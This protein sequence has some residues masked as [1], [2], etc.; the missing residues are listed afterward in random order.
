MQRGLLDN[1]IYKKGRFTACLMEM[2]KT[3]GPTSLYRG[4]TV[5]LFAILF[6][7][8]VLP[9]TTDLLMDKLPLYIDPKRIENM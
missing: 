9:M 2:I 7:M 8:S 5:H 6:W 4:Y 3:E 1:A